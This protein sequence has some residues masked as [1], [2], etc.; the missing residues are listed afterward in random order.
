MDSDP[1]FDKEN[2]FA[3][4]VKNGMDRTQL[5][6][7]VVIWANKQTLTPLMAMA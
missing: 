1:H 3:E 4:N 5:I 2:I 7:D 6:W